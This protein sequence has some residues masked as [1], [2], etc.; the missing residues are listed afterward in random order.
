MPEVP[1]LLVGGI[2]EL[3][4][5]L[6]GQMIVA[7]RR[8]AERRRLADSGASGTI[9]ALALN[10]IRQQAD[11]YTTLLALTTRDCLWLPDRTALLWKD[12]RITSGN[13]P[14]HPEY[15][16]TGDR[17]TI[18]KTELPETVKI[19]A[20]G[21][22]MTLIQHPALTSEMIVREVLDGIYHTGAACVLVDLD[23]PLYLFSVANGSLKL[24]PKGS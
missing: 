19:A 23:L 2:A 13:Q 8:F 20:L 16:W 4:R 14:G 5:L 21:K 12:G 11:V 24:W 9:D 7:E 3:H 18:W 17:F 22:A 6:S 10:C 15:D 1:S